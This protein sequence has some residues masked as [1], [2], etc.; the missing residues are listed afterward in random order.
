MASLLDIRTRMK[1]IDDLKKITN[2]MYMVSS[3]RFKSAQ[4]Q[5]KYLDDLT[6]KQMEI[7]SKIPFEA[8]IMEKPPLFIVIGSDRGLAGGYNANLFD[9]VYEKLKVHKAS[10]I[11]TLGRQMQKLLVR[12]DFTIIEGYTD[13]QKNLPDDIL[14]NMI[15]QAV[16][17]YDSGSEVY[18][19]YTHFTGGLRLKPKIQKLLPPLKTKGHPER[20]YLYEPSPE[21]LIKLITEFYLKISLKSFFFH[22]Y[23]SEQAARMVAM[24]SATDNANELLEDLNAQYQRQRKEIITREITEIVSGANG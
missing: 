24:E 11:I 18:A 6:V 23:A 8:K 1:G 16:Q 3:I 2:T 12:Q 17:A 19:A 15:Q 9:K 14:N 10:R 7:M 22:A 20:K 21:E 4:N 13:I 5:V